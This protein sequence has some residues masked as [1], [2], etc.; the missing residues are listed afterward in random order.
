MIEHVQEEVESG[1]ETS[2]V[3]YS[4][5]MYTYTTY[6]ETKCHMIDT[7]LKVECNIGTMNTMSTYQQLVDWLQHLSGFVGQLYRHQVISLPQTD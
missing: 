6:T 7:V 5:R 3:K 1:D 2:I 4:A